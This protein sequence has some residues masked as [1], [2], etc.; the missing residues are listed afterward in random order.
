MWL[1]ILSWVCTVLSG[2]LAS[3]VYISMGSC[4]K[5]K[6]FW[7]IRKQMQASPIYAH[8]VE[9]VGCELYFPKP[10]THQCINTRIV[11]RKTIFANI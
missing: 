8:E 7:L 9:F 6:L 1:V 3:P 10:L 11:L 2:V 5:I 4:F